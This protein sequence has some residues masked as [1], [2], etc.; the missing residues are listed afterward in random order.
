MRRIIIATAGL[1]LF[2]LSG[3]MPGDA[4]ADGTICPVPGA[5]TFE[6]RL[7]A[8]ERENGR[9]SCRERVS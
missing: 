9:A 5:P 7:L 6:A 1:L 4:P 8:I 3:S 2:S